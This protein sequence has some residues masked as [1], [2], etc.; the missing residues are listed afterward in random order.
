[1]KENTMPKKTTKNLT[2]SQQRFQRLTEISQAT[3]IA[4]ETESLWSEICKPELEFLPSKDVPEFLVLVPEENLSV[5]IAKVEVL[6]GKVIVSDREGI[7]CFSQKFT[8][9]IAGHVLGVVASLY[10]LMK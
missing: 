2:E 1:M 10:L 4:E 6:E 5:F 3:Y 8:K 9:N 7:I